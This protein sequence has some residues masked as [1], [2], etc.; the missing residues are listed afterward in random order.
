MYT[1]P[2]FWLDPRDD[3][4][5]RVT[6]HNDWMLE[7]ANQAEVHLTPVQIQVLESL[8]STTEIDEIRMVAVMAGL[9]R[10]RDYGNRISVQFYAEESEAGVFLWSIVRAMPRVT[11]DRFP[12]LTIQNLISDAVARLSLSDLV[13]KLNRGDAVMEPCGEPI[14]YN[15]AFV[16]K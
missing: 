10:I 13:E 3:S 8:D 14:P 16:R 5:Y 2:G 7:S 6:T 12:F 1:G 4:L 15:Q 9:V 11:K